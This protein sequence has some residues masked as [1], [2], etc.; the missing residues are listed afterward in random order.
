[1]SIKRSLSLGGGGGGGGSTDKERR[2]TGNL[3]KMFS[4]KNCS[5]LV[6]NQANTG[7]KRRGGEGSGRRRPTPL[8]AGYFLEDSGYLCSCFFLLCWL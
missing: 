4:C 1:M 7:G 5:L 2:M 3:F 8:L 6:T